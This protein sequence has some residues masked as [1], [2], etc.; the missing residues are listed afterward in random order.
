LQLKLLGGN[1]LEKARQNGCESRSGK[2]ESKMW[3]QCIAENLRKLVRYVLSSYFQRVFEDA[4]KCNDIIGDSI[5]L[6]LI[7]VSFF[8]ANCW[9]FR[10]HDTSKDA[11]V[12][13]DL[14]PKTHLKDCMD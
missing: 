14:V 4:K 1:A 7:H 6:F 12:I 11:S 2:T 5:R 3:N 10:E 9:F 13:N 8:L